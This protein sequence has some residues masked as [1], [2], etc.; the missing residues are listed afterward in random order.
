MGAARD[1][2]AAD[3]R[4]CHLQH[5][6]PN[7]YTGFIGLQPQFC[8]LCEHD[9]HGTDVQPYTD[10][11]PEYLDV[12]SLQDEQSPD[13]SRS[14]IALW[15]SNSCVRIFHG[16]LLV[17]GDRTVHLELQQRFPPKRSNHHCQQ[18]VHRQGERPRNCL[19]DRC[20]SNR[21]RT[22]L[23]HDRHMVQGSHR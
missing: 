17:V 10:D 5:H 8:V 2:L 12:L 9:H 23:C 18:M 3:Q 16:Q 22:L 11:F 19:T 6:I 7:R 20:W 1:R 21:I 13:R 4:L 15:L 14:D